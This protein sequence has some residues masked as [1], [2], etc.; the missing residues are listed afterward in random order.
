M[1]LNNKVYDYLKWTALVLIPALSALYVGLGQI[2]D[3]NYVVEVVSTLTT[4]ELF[5]GALLGITTPG[6]NKERVD[7]TI[8]VMEGENSL[9]Y[10]L[11]LDKNP[12]ALGRKDEVVFKVD[13]N[14]Q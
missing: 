4:V 2:W 3:L 1:S 14:P 7:G 5:I 10:D 6:W 11:A 13:R 12:E 8:N 9:K